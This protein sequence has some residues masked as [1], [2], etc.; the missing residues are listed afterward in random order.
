MSEETSFGVGCFHFW[1]LKKAPY[2][3][4]VS[5]Y[6]NEV[7]GALQRITTIN[8]IYIP[9]IFT[10]KVDFEYKIAD[11]KPRALSKGDDYF[12][13]SPFLQMHFDLYIPFRIQKELYT[14]ES[15]LMKTFTEN[16]RVYM[17]YDIYSPVTFV[18]P[19]NPSEKPNPSQAVM[20]VR[21]YLRREVNT[22]NSEIKFDVLGPSPFHAEYYLTPFE[23]G[24]KNKD[25]PP[26][27]MQCLKLKGYDE[28]NFYYDKSFFSNLSEARETLFYILRPE[29]G[30]F[31]KLELNNLR[32]MQEWVSVQGVLEKIVPSDVKKRSLPLISGTLLRGRHIKKL[33]TSIIIFECN[34]IFRTTEVTEEY[35][36]V[37]SK[38]EPT[39]L[40]YYIDKQ[41]ENK[42]SYPTRQIN[43]LALFFE[44]HRSKALEMLVV[45]LSALLGGAAGSLL[46]I[47][48]SR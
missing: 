17:L 35:D 30:L 21:Q 39:F 19:L 7:R 15:K 8:N 14:R 34:D 31:Y 43:E 44:N 38:E 11:S 46:T 32:S 5:E 22:P 1:L 9:H 45:L 27:E 42:P 48:L 23:D 36:R 28:I 26:I 12:P 3:I 37:Y 24:S 47:V 16:F 2:T 6:I 13:R 29:L 20:I 33:F 4:N 10:S 40:K 41:R 25:G 18:E